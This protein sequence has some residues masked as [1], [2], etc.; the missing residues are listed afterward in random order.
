MSGTVWAVGLSMTGSY[1]ITLLDYDI[2]DTYD[3]ADNIRS[4]SF[5]QTKNTFSDHCFLES[6]E[7]EIRKK[8]SNET[9]DNPTTEYGGFGFTFDY[10][11][12][13]HFI[14]ISSL[15]VNNTSSSLFSKDKKSFLNY[16]AIKKSFTEA[17]IVYLDE[18]NLQFGLGLELPLYGAFMSIPDMSINSYYYLSLSSY[19]N[20]SFYS[21]AT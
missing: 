21:D 18:W 14:L 2:G 7:R 20:Y 8:N 3:N 10:S 1:A 6:E 16:N 5:M 15:R 9:L 11:T 4:N 17:N 12:N 19:I 13:L